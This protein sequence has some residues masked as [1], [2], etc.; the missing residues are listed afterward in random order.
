MG[1]HALHRSQTHH[2]AKQSSHD[3]CL[4]PG[5]Q[6]LTQ[7]FDSS[8][9]QPS[10]RTQQSTFLS[11]AIP[12]SGQTAGSAQ[13]DDE[14]IEQRAILAGL[15]AA[16]HALDAATSPAQL[17]AGCE[18]AIV[19]LNH[20]SHAVATFSG[21]GDQQAVIS[22]ANSFGLS[23]ERVRA[24]APDAIPVRLQILNALIRNGL[25]L[26]SAV[27]TRTEANKETAS[28]ASY[29]RNAIPAAL[30][31]IASRA[32][33]GRELLELLPPQ[34]PQRDGQVATLAEALDTSSRYASSLLKQL[35]FE[36]GQSFVN[37]VQLAASEMMPLVRWVR[38]RTP[39]K[40]MEQSMSSAIAS[41]DV[42][43]R[44][45][46]LPIIDNREAATLSER[47]L[48]TAQEEHDDVE[49][50]AGTLRDAIGALENAQ[51]SAVAAFDE[52]ARLED[53]VQPNL[54]E[55][56]LKAAVVAAMGACAAELIKI[57]STVKAATATTMAVMRSPQVTAMLA[58]GVNTAN[59]SF[60]ASW[61][62]VTKDNSVALAR[63][64]F[65][66]AMREDIQAKSDAYRAHVIQLKKE[67]AAS[68]A[69]LQLMCDAIQGAAKAVKAAYV[70]QLAHHWATYLAKSR[71]GT[72]AG[73]R[74]NMRDYFGKP[75]AHGREF[76]TSNQ[77]TPGVMQ[78]LMVVDRSGR[79]PRQDV[80][81][82]KIV[83]L[84]SQLTANVID[85]ARHDLDKV[86]VPKE[87]HVHADFGRAMIAVDESNRYKD[88][89]NW[90][91][92][93]RQ[94]GMTAHQFWKV[95]GGRLTI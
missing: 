30:Q 64:V 62:K 53:V 94:V 11:G 77:A 91:Q 42:V 68:A 59:A 38:S 76:G 82:T 14:A 43:S 50:A 26:D 52:L 83:G 89:I 65:S 49:A 22:A 32:R 36:E 69:E 88:A 86:S 35:S 4:A 37:D 2:V 79:A 15:R 13:L 39:H 63:I 16:Q 60:Q 61:A 27:S 25:A 44:S 71:L 47:G 45:V 85:A 9:G 58:I 33:A 78:L 23:L 74:A 80:S 10:A 12:W 31:M 57:L 81:A 72:S 48:S 24:R 1:D 40:E 90:E 21:D 87:L 93:Q 28:D 70:Q 6:T 55:T 20:V 29:V 46:G 17:S 73:D 19:H 3:V 56:I 54:V 18:E 41:F 75:T 7:P 5:K 92:V 51:T 8:A 34:S 67:S 84:N 95:Y 66:S